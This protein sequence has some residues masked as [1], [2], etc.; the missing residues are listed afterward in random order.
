MRLAGEVPGSRPESPVSVQ[1]HPRTFPSSQEQTIVEFTNRIS[2]T[3][4]GVVGPPLAFLLPLYVNTQ[5][6]GQLV[7]IRGESDM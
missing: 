7:L 4:K 1:V 5:F 6:G 2:V 3:S